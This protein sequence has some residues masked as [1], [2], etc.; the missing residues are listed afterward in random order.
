VG[1]MDMRPMSAKSR[2]VASVLIGVALLALTVLYI[3]GSGSGFEGIRSTVSSGD[4]GTL[5]TSRSADTPP[6]DASPS[7]APREPFVTDL[8][9]PA[10]EA[11]PGRVEEVPV[12]PE[13]YVAR[14]RAI[15]DRLID[16]VLIRRAETV[17]SRAGQPGLPE[18]L[19][20]DAWRWVADIMKQY[21]EEDKPRARLRYERIWEI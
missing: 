2:W 11:S 12:V 21:L 8:D 10:R 13:G 7:P 9:L 14:Q 17:L 4:G 20:P 19:P 16:E 15:D 3:S 1:S 18:H 6:S 5:Q